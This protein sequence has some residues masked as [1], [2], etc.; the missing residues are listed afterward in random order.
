MLTDG[1]ACLTLNVVLPGAEESD[2]IS[3]GY[4]TR[5]ENSWN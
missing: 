2:N 1:Y 3:R 5:R 4:L